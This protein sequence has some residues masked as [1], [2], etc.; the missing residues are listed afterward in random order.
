MAKYNGP[1]RGTMGDTTY[2]D[3]KHG[4]T[5]RKKGGV[6]AERIRTDPKFARVREQQVEFASATKAGRLLRNSIIKLVKGNSD[7]LT[8]SRLAKAFNKVVKSDAIND[9]GFR[10][11]TDGDLNFMKDFEFNQ[12]SALKTSLQVEVSS[13]MNRVT[14]EL[15]VQI[16]ALVPDEVVEAPQEATHYRIVSAGIALDFKNEKYVSEITTTPDLPLGNVQQAVID[17]VNHVTPN[18]QDHLFVVL[19]IQYYQKIGN[20]KMYILNNGAYNSLQVLAV[21]KGTAV[22]ATP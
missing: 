7:H 11:V 8:T 21:S 15:S 18:T 1:I 5:A 20:G 22:P 9:R 3:S 17:L 13:A 12:Q 10:N 2:Y 14:G 4:P 19:G 6:S 16:P